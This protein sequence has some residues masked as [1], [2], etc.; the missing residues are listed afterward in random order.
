MINILDK[1]EQCN[2]VGRHTWQD[3]TLYLGHSAS[4]IEFRFKGTKLDV[5]LVTDLYKDTEKKEDVYHAWLAVFI[6]NI[7]EPAKRIEL[8][9]NQETFTVFES[10]LEQEVSIRLMKY[11]EAAFSK[12]GFKAI[13]LEGELFP[14]PTRKPRRIEFIGDSITCG[15][16]IE[17]RPNSDLFTTKEENPMLAYACQTAKLLN[18]EFQLV[19]WSG[20]GIITNYVDVTV[21]EPFPDRWLMPDLYQYTDGELERSL[22]KSTYEVWDNKRYVPDL[23]VIYLGT[24][25]A[26]Y[27]R[28]IKERQEYFANEYRKFLD[29]VRA[30]NKDSYILCVLGSMNQELCEIEERMVSSKQAD[31][32]NKIKFLA[33]PLQR[34][35]DGLGA[36]GHPTPITHFKVAEQIA[37]V[38]KEWLDWN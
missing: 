3:Q 2:I 33:L 7:E 36:H 27:T 25:D 19:S 6:N 35:E 5:T 13:S 15:Y 16:G 20:I 31:G 21:N 28:G 12:L 8:C 9:N 14:S 29:K 1:K 17:G 18:A 30:K 32:D 4:Y 37:L 10:M 11:S 34:E 22:Q 24:N 38:V 26:S 23:V